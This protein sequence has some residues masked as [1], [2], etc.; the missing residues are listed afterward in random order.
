[1]KKQQDLSV[2]AQQRQEQLLAGMRDELSGSTIELQALR[3]AV[4][5]SMGAS[6]GKELHVVRRGRERLEAA[7]QRGQ[8]HRTDATAARKHQRSAQQQLNALQKHTDKLSVDLIRKAA[9]ANEALKV[10]ASELEQEQLKAL[11]LEEQLKAAA[12]Q[13]LDMEQQQ[14]RHKELKHRYHVLNEARRAVQQQVQELEDQLEAMH[15]E[16]DFGQACSDEDEGQDDDDDFE[17]ETGA[18]AHVVTEQVATFALRSLQCG[19]HAC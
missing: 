14:R 5:E 16:L 9:A 1:M 13:E 2:Q 10:K 15:V 4:Q 17:P 8:R 7:K 19:R 12:T 3:Q 11:A 18:G 6:R